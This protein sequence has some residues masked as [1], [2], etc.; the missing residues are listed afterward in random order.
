M[1]IKRALFTIRF[2]KTKVPNWRCPRCDGG[3]LRLV[4]DTFRT[5]RS[6]DSLANSGEEWYDFDMEESRFVALLQCD[7]DD[8]KETAS[9][10]GEGRVIEDPDLEK[11]K[12]DYS[13]VFFATHIYPSPPL[14]R[15]PV[16]CPEQVACQIS[17]VN[18]SQWNAPDAAATRVR[19]TVE[20]LLTD[21]GI[22]VTR[23]TK[24]G[25]ERIS[26]HQ[27]IELLK[28]ERPA[29]ADQLLAMKWIGN[30]GA[31]DEPITR[32]D[33]FDML[34]ILENILEQI[35]GQVEKLAQLVKHINNRRGPA[36]RG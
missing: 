26:L 33:V 19:V 31:H 6:G 27:R 9:L 21:L 5:A 16:K 4:P 15:L 25:E 10:A 20:R 30:A 32:E 24:R 3:H 28:N 1:P 18:E 8:C 11:H 36:H 34:D 22:P 35:Y 12:M 14:I 7:N 2:S 13:E 17:L 23:P 29:Q